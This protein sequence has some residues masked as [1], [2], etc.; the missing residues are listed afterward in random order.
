LTVAVGIFLPVFAYQGCVSAHLVHVDPA[1]SG[2]A[3]RKGKLAVAGVVLGRGVAEEPDDVRKVIRNFESELRDKRPGIALVENAA[4][5]SA[6][7]DAGCRELRES[8]TAGESPGRGADSAKGLAT[9]KAMGIANV[10]LIEMGYD[11]VDRYV[12]TSSDVRNT[13]DAATGQPTGQVVR[14]TTTSHTKRAV[15][16]TYAIYDVDSGSK[17]WASQSSNTRERVRTA[18]SYDGYPEAPDYAPVP[19]LLGVIRSM[20]AAAVKKLPREATA[21]VPPTAPEAA[22]GPAEAGAETGAETGASAAP[23]ISE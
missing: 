10:L 15:T 13:V 12:T 9:L 4:V 11:T 3:L 19:S 5:E 6:L 18:D 2:D 23:G 7:G 21:A 14:Y 8:L 17:I 22:G 16:A 1:F 20:A